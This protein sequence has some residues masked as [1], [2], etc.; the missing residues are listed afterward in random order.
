MKRKIILKLFTLGLLLL[1]INSCSYSVLAASGY[2][3]SAGGT[4][5]NWNT[6]SLIQ[7]G[8]NTYNNLGYSAQ[9]MMNPSFNTLNNGKNADGSKL[10]E[11]K[12][13]LLAGHGN[14]AGTSIKL[15]SSSYLRTGN[16]TGNSVGVNNV[17]FS[18]VKLIT[19]VG[20][21]TSYD[22]YDNYSNLA[23]EIF[24]KSAGKANVVGFKQEV[25]SNIMAEWCANYHS[26]LKSGGTVVQAIQYAN[27]KSYRDSRV[28]DIGYFGTDTTIKS[29]SL[30]TC[31]IPLNDSNSTFIQKNIE[32]TKENQ[33]VQGIV[34]FIKTIN[35]SFNVND[36]IINIYCLNKEQDIYTID[37]IR[38]IG[39][40]YT[41]LGYVAN[42]QYGKLIS[43][44]DNNQSIEDIKIEEF[45]NTK[46]KLSN[47]KIVSLKKDAIK[48]LK[49]KLMQN[50]VS[51]FSVENQKCQYYLD[52]KT[53]KKYYDIFTT[54]KDENN[55]INVDYYSIE[56]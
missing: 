40:F 47:S 41:N 55:T 2:A 33:N 8:N 24:R 50:N 6:T 10:L 27:S 37:F 29:T 51:T 1:I 48:Y 13:V 20:C 7:N 19:L 56:I 11:S 36:Y 25:S 22:P 31:S 18:K 26:K 28:K 43:I 30:S 39:N 53:N 16:T 4:V 21:K 23:V 54:Y 49:N 42:I 14:T 15:S 45:P 46:I 38:K 17:N 32:F 44:T 35:P 34:D 9:Y 12:V 3:F 52:V 5:D